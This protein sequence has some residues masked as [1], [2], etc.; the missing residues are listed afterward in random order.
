[1]ADLDATVSNEQV[2]IELVTTLALKEA[3]ALQHVNVLETRFFKL[4]E[5]V[6]ADTAC[7]IFTPDDLRVW[8]VTKDELLADKSGDLHER[9]ADAYGQND[10]EA[11]KILMELRHN[12]DIKGNTIL[13]MTQGKSVLSIDKMFDAFPL[14]QI[15]VDHKS[16]APTLVLVFPA[17]TIDKM[18]N[19]D[20]AE[21]ALKYPI[22][23]AW[24]L[25][26]LWYDKKE[27]SSVGRLIAEF[28]KRYNGPTL[29]LWLRLIPFARVP[30]FLKK[31]WLVPRKLGTVQIKK[32]AAPKKEQEETEDGE[33]EDDDEAEATV[34]VP[35]PT[36]HEKKV[37]E[38]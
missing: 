27:P 6:P 5:Y 23:R 35:P 14:E 32:D 10:A 37:T 31:R 20:T 7:F 21:A 9:L 1:M 26:A 15:L 38:D 4:K 3:K 33:D 25:L 16:R 36:P 30:P 8:T 22:M 19:M 28:D 12:E 11:R 2:L 29:E 34:V 13:Y 17:E 24:R 18:P